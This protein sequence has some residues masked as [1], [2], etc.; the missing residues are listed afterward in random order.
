MALVS[1]MG[2]FVVKRGQWTLICSIIFQRQMPLSCN[3]SVLH[4]KSGPPKNQLT[5]G[6]EI[7]IQNYNLNEM[8]KKKKE[9]G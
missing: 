4:H 6:E 3:C 8:K 5:P 2:G 9:A 1:E 7:N